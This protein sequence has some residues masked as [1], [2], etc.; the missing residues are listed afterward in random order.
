MRRNVDYNKS[1]AIHLL[2]GQLEELYWSSDMHGGIPVGK[3]GSVSISIDWITAISSWIIM[4]STIPLS[5]DQRCISS[6]SNIL[7]VAYD[8]CTYIFCCECSVNRRCAYRIRQSHLCK[9]RESGAL[10]IFTWTAIILLQ[11]LRWTTTA[12]AADED[13][14]VFHLPIGYF[15]FCCGSSSCLKINTVTVTYFEHTIN[16]K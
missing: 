16:C 4:I 11:H 3:V 15:C 1:T 8:T 5:P 12:A 9:Q 10:A 14:K 13:G 2:K 7:V 6:R